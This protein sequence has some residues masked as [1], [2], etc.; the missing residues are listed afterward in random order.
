MRPDAIDWTSTNRHPSLPFPPRLSLSRTVLRWT[1]AMLALQCMATATA[2]VALTHIAVGPITSLASI[3]DAR[4]VGASPFQLAGILSAL[5][6]VLV[7]FVVLL[8][9]FAVRLSRWTVVLVGLHKQLRRL[10]QGAEP[11]PVPVQGADELA[12][13]ALA[14]NHMAGC[15]IEHRRQLTRVNE[16]LER[17]VELRTGELATAAA[18]LEELATSDVLT[19]LSNRYAMMTALE[20]MFVAARSANLDLVC[21]AIDLD[22]FKGVNDT[23][24]HAAGDELLKIAGDLFKGVCREGDVAARQGGDE[25]ILLL[26][27]RQ[28]RDAQHIAHRLLDGFAQSSRRWLAGR[29]VPHPPSL[30]IGIATLEHCGA[31]TPDGLLHAADEALYAA[32][33]AGKGRF[34]FWRRPTDRSADAEAA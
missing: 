32:K 17:R 20:S 7:P 26:P 31:L 11:S 22:G 24:G 10:A 21:L 18:R 28:P 19:S 15:L 3:L 30:S 27:M 13:L 16:D 5:V 34:E 8:P 2:F 25:F 23:L 9:L 29:I 33:R 12:Y 6:G 14:F 1:L 4:G